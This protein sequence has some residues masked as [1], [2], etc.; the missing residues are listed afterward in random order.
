VK[1]VQRRLEEVLKD[2]LVVMEQRG[3]AKY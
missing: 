3:R 2:S 1:T